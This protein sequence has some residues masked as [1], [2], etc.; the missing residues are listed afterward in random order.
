MCRHPVPNH[1]FAV[2]CFN[3][4][5]ILLASWSHKEIEQRILQNYPMSVGRVHIKS[6]LDAYAPLDFE[7]GFLDQFVCHPLNLN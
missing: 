1:G 5:I 2:G 6:G 7:S 3:V 4:R